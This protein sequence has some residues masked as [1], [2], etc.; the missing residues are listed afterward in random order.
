MRTVLDILCFYMQGEHI[1]RMLTIVLARHCRIQL[2]A[3][4]EWATLYMANLSQHQSFFL[5]ALCRYL[6]SY[7][8][9]TDRKE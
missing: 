9:N 2:C 4:D 1:L 8:K 3:V 7:S 6:S 5:S